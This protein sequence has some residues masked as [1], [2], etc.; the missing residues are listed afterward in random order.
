MGEHSET[1]E[2]R[3]REAFEAG[4]H[5]RAAT[6]TIEQYGPE[7]LGFL[8]SQC[9][10]ADTAHE[11]FAQFCAQFWETL[12]SFEWR[13]SMRTWVYKLVRHAAARQRR[14]E[15]ARGPARPL[16][17]PSELSIAAERVRTVT[18]MHQ[19]TDVK[20]RLQE[21]RATLPR[22]EQELLIL[23]VDRGLSWLEL[24]EVMTGPGEPASD[25]RLKAEAARLRKRFQ[26][27]KQRLRQLVVEAGLLAQ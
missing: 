22:E 27:A 15:R 8:L 24:A 2:R 7:L 25:A 1:L 12:S 14:G 18:A 21:L 19:R 20:D 17:H 16:T 9:R 10:D 4:S 6:L 11:I 5:A 26:L 13:C 23:R 3:I